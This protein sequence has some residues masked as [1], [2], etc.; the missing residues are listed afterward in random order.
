MGTIPPGFIPDK[1]AAALPAGF[2]PDKPQ[3][4]A[5]PPGFTPDDGTALPPLGTGAPRNPRTGMVMHEAP[6]GT[7]PVVDTAIEDLGTAVAP[8]TPW[9]QRII[10]GVGGALDLAAPA[11]PIE[12]GEAVAAANLPRLVR[13]LATLGIGFGTQ[14]GATA[15]AN[16][17]GLDPL[18]AQLVGMGAGIGSG[19]YSGK[20][21]GVFDRLLG[22][23]KAG[24][25]LKT[26][27]PAPGEAPP[28]GGV[29][30][31]RT[32]DIAADPNR[33]QFKLDAQGAGGTSRLLK[34]VDTYNPELAGTVSVWTD[35]ADGKTYVVNGHH[36]LE[37]ARRTG[38][39]SVAVRSLNAPDAITARAVGAL[40][41]I[42]EGRGTAV[43]AAKFFR[44]SGLTP[45]ELRASG[46]SMGEATARQGAA[47]ARLD[48]GLFNQV[49]QG[50]LRPARAV[51]IAEATSDPV[52]QRTIAKMVADREAAG[53]PV[54]D[55]S[56]AEMARLVKSSGQHVETQQTL[57]GPEQVTHS[58]A[59]E[60][61]DISSYIKQQIE[62]DRR[63]FSAVASQ[64]TAARLEGEGNKIA[65]DRNAEVA[66][67]AAQ[68]GALYDT[69][70]THAGPV[71][72]TLEDAARRIANGEDP[73]AVKQQAY[74]AVQAQLSDA[75]KTATNR[76]AGGVEAPSGVGSQ[77]EGPTA[78]EGPTSDA[79]A[80]PA[81]PS[82]FSSASSASPIA[83]APAPTQPAVAQSRQRL[84]ESLLRPSATLGQAAQY[85]AAKVGLAKLAEAPNYDDWSKAM[86]EDVG[87]S[88][89][90]HLQQVWDIV[91]RH[92]AMDRMASNINLDRLSSSQDIEDAI[93]FTAAAN[94]ADIETQRRDAIPL[95]TTR[96]VAEQMVSDGTMRETDLAHVKKGTAFNASQA[97]AAR[98]ILLSLAEQATDAAAAYQA[99]PSDENN[100][101]F[102]AALKR[103]AAVQKSVSGITAE[104][105]RALSSFRIMAQALKDKSGFQAAL[106]LVGGPEVSADI[107]AKL[108]AFD[109]ADHVGRMRF[110][111]DQQQYGWYDRILGYYKANLLAS[112]RP[113]VKKV[114]G[115]FVL[116]SLENL[117][118]IVRVPIDKGVAALQGR[119][120]E[121][122]AAEFGPSVRAWIGSLPEGMGKAAEIMRHGFTSSQAE[123]L[124]LPPMEL[125]G[126]GYNPLNWQ[127]RALSAATE[128]F[129]TMQ[130]NA[131]LRSLGVR[132]AIREG[133][134]GSDLADRAAALMADP[135]PW[136]VD[137]A[138]KQGEF[139]TFTNQT[140]LKGGLSAMELVLDKHGG[141]VTE[142]TIGRML[143]WIVPFRKIPANILLRGID[144]SPLGLANLADA[145]VRQSP[146]ASNAISRAVIGSTLM[147]GAAGLASRG[148]LTGSAPKNPRARAAW[149]AA[150]NRPF[151]VKIAGRW[152]PYATTTGSIG[153]PLAAT[154]AMFDAH[155]A[156]QPIPSIGQRIA[157]GGFSI[158]NAMLQE[159]FLES[160]A[161]MVNAI[162]DPTR[163]SETELSGLMSGMLPA[164]GAWREVA[165]AIDPR[166]RNARGVYDKVIAGLPFLRQTLPVKFDGMGMPIV[167]PN[168][169]FQTLMPGAAASSSPPDGEAGAET[170]RLGVYPGA[171]ESSVLIR[172]KRVSL[173]PAQAEDFQQFVG[174]AQRRAAER[175]MS[176]GGYW[177]MDDE[178]RARTLKYAMAGARRAAEAAWTSGLR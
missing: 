78:S 114:L 147:L 161:N 142:K 167:S 134:S 42:A 108:A 106:D 74:Q 4:T 135:E 144:Y 115:D 139:A 2:V 71:A 70:S 9:Q 16:K 86:V 102:S 110:I 172:R 123:K 177:G 61:G 94:P 162:Q 20:A 120:Q 153:I 99:D 25:P 44:D 124:E 21:L 121:F 57:F 67:Q 136:M 157:E 18:D 43:D 24:A 8:S 33:F 27:V 159:T 101:R 132:Q 96:Q 17:L 151:S 145:T 95:G 58:L 137:K 176:A 107:A 83:A 149:F 38:Q 66:Q 100:V 143:D 51:A 3:A 81:S 26:V 35:P 46:I 113:I 22:T 75:L 89:Q 93:K 103:M 105:G 36:R 5:T 34:G 171:T 141:T 90:P 92:A 76:G 54:T 158:G 30:L 156:G 84:V 28:A 53:K 125:P 109:P 127:P 7:I 122:Y 154:A 14:A 32:E 130:S 13:L 166:V 72:D 140:G 69:L 48:D 150:G 37:L 169:G 1:G 88:I 47:L 126:A 15:A 163:Y 85:S 170:A 175:V 62:R 39:P 97:V 63:A 174:Q 10:S 23:D 148:L 91:Q 116:G 104:A 164:G 82:L 29:G 73:S 155:Q 80:G 11:I 31:M 111:R 6:L 152:F 55:A 65:V 59:F 52:Q 64:D 68:A 168:G 19:A 119:P 87:P 118:R 128:A 56:L 146:E 45:E 98:G 77:D 12:G 131:E 60:K 129:G 41:N 50:E 160:V 178:Q 79:A 165:D 117:N 138:Q 173:T 49:V 40:Q 112:T 133:L